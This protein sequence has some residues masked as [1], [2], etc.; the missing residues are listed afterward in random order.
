MQPRPNN[1]KIIE[2]EMLQQGWKVED[3]AAAKASPLWNLGKSG[4]FREQEN[5]DGE[6]SGK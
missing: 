3:I 4:E 6:E 1:N 5:G 2:A